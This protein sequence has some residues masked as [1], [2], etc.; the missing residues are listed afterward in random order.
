MATEPLIV[1]L[2][3]KVGKLEADLLS[4]NKK[5][6]KLDKQTEKNDSSFKKLSATSIGVAKTLGAAA[7]A[8]LALATAM[9]AIIVSSAKS[10]KEL[11]LLSR[12]AKLS[13][14]DFES[15]SFATSQ[16]GINAEQIA[17]IS[18]DLSD[19][20][21]EFGKVGTGAFQDYAD[22]IG[23]TKDQAK[24]AA[25]EFEN[26]SSDQ[27][28]GQMVSKMEEAGASA[29][30]MTFV[31]ESM[32][33]DLSRLLPLF[34]DNNVEL[35]KLRNRYDNVSKSMAITSKE[36]KGLEVVSTNFDLMTAS[37]SKSGTL[38][39]AQLAPMLS[40]FFSSVITVVPQATQV[41]IDFINSFKDAADVTNI[42][43][44][45][46]LQKEAIERVAEAQEKL[47]DAISKGGELGG[48]GIQSDRVTLLTSQI[49]EATAR[50]EE[51][52]EQIVRLE[53][54]TTPK[55]GDISA[56]L[57]GAAVGG[58]GG[59][60]DELAALED[61]FK[62]EELLLGEKLERELIIASENNEL[63]LQ[64]H[65]EFIQAIMELDNAAEQEEL[66]RIDRLAKAD[67]KAKKSALKD[68]D[69]KN[70]GQATSD[71]IYAGVALDVAGEIF[72]GNKAADAGLVVTKT[73]VAVMH[74]M[75]SGDPYTAF[76]RAAAVAVAGA[77]QLGNVLSASEGGGSVSSAGG[78]AAVTEVPEPT[79]ELAVSST[80]EGGLGR[81]IVIRFES[82]DNDALAVA[83][84]GILNEA[85]VNGAI[86]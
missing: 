85:T 28:I 40:E 83:L 72:E 76:A 29:N 18:K 31:L 27:V 7:T 50:A 46:N 62:S 15:L 75:G 4:V 60:G 61:R 57:G 65:K 16:Y 25:I 9:S 6:D 70:K 19:K 11:E 71:Q 51:L 81:D 13:T 2:D 26:M 5:L 36:A 34:A 14:Q 74:Q 58:T 63:K 80:E 23:L 73:A 78:D 55:G 3:S 39:S 67:E 69:K 21:G 38:I 56:T 52:G 84:N 30:E 54:A 79:S 35:D 66:E 20:M 43:S 1:Q 41:V 68:T 32:G 33:N 44:A 48:K 86:S 64:L 24:A 45:M 17:D 59:T 8:G 82:G 42:N 10:Q 53:G 22:I 37:L 49:E 47:N 77:V 12:Q